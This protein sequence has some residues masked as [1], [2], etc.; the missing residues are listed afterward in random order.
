MKGFIKKEDKI[1]I[2]KKTIPHEFGIG[3]EVSKSRF[4]RLPNI[5]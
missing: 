1:N 3:A 2:N 4:F 5:L